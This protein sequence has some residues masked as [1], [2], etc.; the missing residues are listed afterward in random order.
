VADDRARFKPGIAA[1]D[2]PSIQGGQFLPALRSVEFSSCYVYSPHGGGYGSASARL[3]CTRLKSGDDTW[4]PIYARV[5]REQ[6]IQRHV[7]SNLFAKNGFLVP[8]PGSAPAS[9]GV[10]A[11]QSLALALHGVGLGGFVWAGIERRFAVRK[12]ATALSAQRPSVRQHYESFA[13]SR[14]S[15]LPESPTRLVIV[16]DVITK[17]RTILAAAIRL[18]EAFPNADIRAFALV[19]TMGFVSKVGGA[20]DPCQGVVRWAGGD[21]R[22]EP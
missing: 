3:L 6:A 12:S 11:A 4:L 16:D 19:R 15:T 5:V 22:R 2:A 18:H 13:V 17:G 10:W 20:L 14:Q 8:V 7:L 1:D 21:A 9:H